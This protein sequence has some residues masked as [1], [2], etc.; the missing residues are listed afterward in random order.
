MKL[1]PG[2]YLFTRN[3]LGSRDPE[4]DVAVAWVLGP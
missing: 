1:T 4:D 3:E 2:D